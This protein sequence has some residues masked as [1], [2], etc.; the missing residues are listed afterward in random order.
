[1]KYGDAVIAAVVLVSACTGP[2]IQ[3]KS[4]HPAPRA[5]QPRAVETVQTF[6]SR[7]D[8]GVAA[9]SLEASGSDQVAI[10]AAVKQ[11]AASLG[12]DGIMF[13]VRQDP[14][15]ARGD[16][17]TGQ[18]NQHREYLAARID[19]LCMVLPNGGAGTTPPTMGNP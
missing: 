15:Q 6:E 2:N 16:A 4:L 7:P 18:L 3:V 11:R 9:Y 8:G 10:E 13:T 14:S 17:S 1:M 12:C 19:A 5:L